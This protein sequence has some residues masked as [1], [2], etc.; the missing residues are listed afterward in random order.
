M[1]STTRNAAEHFLTQS[2]L[3]ITNYC[4]AQNKMRLLAILNIFLAFLTEFDGFF[5]IFDAFSPKKIDFGL[6]REH[7]NSIAASVV[8]QNRFFCVKLC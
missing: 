5:D 1:A 7:K 3:Q 2:W 6:I 4:L 8:I